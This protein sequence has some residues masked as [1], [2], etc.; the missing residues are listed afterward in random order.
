M[1]QYFF[2]NFLTQEET[3]EIYNEFMQIQRVTEGDNPFVNDH[4]TPLTEAFYNLPS[5]LKYMPRFQEAMEK[6]YGPNIQFA[7]TFTRLYR[8]GSYLKPHVDRDG[9]DITIS[10]CL[11]RDV[12]WAIHVSPKFIDDAWRNDD[13]YD[14]TAYLKES[15]AFDM[16]PGDFAHCYGRKNP[17]WRT[18][19][20]CGPDQH[21][22][23]VFLHWSF[24]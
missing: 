3:A 17:H 8:N 21:N 20:E 23:Y 4:G 11:R 1:T 19:L 18:K 12:P 24:V 10:F 15:M 14:K 16:L 9:L 22:A 5:T 2:E 7:N 6:I 13:D